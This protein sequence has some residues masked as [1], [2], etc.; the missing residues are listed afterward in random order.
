M[1]A[2][3]FARFDAIGYDNSLR[4]PLGVSPWNAENRP[5]NMS[6]YAIGVCAMVCALLA[7]GNAA[8]WHVEG[9]MPL[10]AS[11]ALAFVFAVAQRSRERT[12]LARATVSRERA[13]RT[14]GDVWSAF[15]DDDAED[16]VDPRFT[17]AE[18]A[19]AAKDGSR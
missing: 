16:P 4:F 17:L 6:R 13:D 5:P 7:L 11:A 19:L 8:F 9:W 14:F 18:A 3:D 12:R 10:G 15:D 1:P 2:T